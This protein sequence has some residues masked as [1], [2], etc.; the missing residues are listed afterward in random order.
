MTNPFKLL[1]AAGAAILLMAAPAAA[2]VA[3]NHPSYKAPAN[4]EVPPDNTLGAALMS[5]SVL[6]GCGASFRGS[7]AVSISR[8]GAGICLVTFVREVRSCS[9]LA[10]VGAFGTTLGSPSL[11]Q[12]EYVGGAA[13]DNVVRVETFNTAG[14]PTDTSFHVFV[15]CWR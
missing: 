15:N 6:S 9:V 8:P 2:Q 13:N 5:A 7:G 14:T 4:P 3:E 1:M 11:I 12:T 10:T